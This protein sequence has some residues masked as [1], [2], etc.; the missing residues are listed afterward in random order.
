MIN[1]RLSTLGSAIVTVVNN[2][3]HV[4]GFM[5]P[6]RLEDYINNNNKCF[7]SKEIYPKSHIDYAVLQDNS[8]LIIRNEN[9]SEEKYCFEQVLKDSIKYKT[10]DNTLTTK[11]YS[12]RK[13]KYTG[14]YNLQLNDESLLFDTLNDLQVEFQKRF[15][16]YIETENQLSL[17]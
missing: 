11:V 5:Y 7:F 16:S 2:E 10:K 4:T 15:N 9:G 14:I 3:Y 8:I 6:E 17:I 1:E 12:I 13:C